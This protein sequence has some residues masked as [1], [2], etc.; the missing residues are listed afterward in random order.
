[1]GTV[2]F[3]NDHFATII[4]YGDYV[5]GNLAICHMY[6]VEGLGH[7]LF[8]VGQFCNRDLEVA[9]CSNTCYILNLEGENL[10]IGSRDSNLY[11]ISI[12]DLVASSPVCLMSKATST[13]SSLEV[14]DNSAANTLDKEDTPLSSS[15]VVEENE[16]PQIVTSSEEL[17][18]NELNTSMLMN[19]FKKKLQKLMEI[20]IGDPSKPVMIGR[21]IYTDAEMYMYALTSRLVAKGYYQE[22]GINFEESFARLEAVRMF[23]AYAAYKNFTIYQ[24]DVKTAFLNGPLKEKAFVSQPNGF[25]DPDFSN[26][27]YRLKKALYGFKQ[28][29]RAWYDKLSSFLIDHHF[30]KGEMKFFLGLQVHQSPRRIFISQSQYTL[31]ILKKHGMEKCDSISTPMATARIDVDLQG[32]STDQTK[33][34][35]MIEGL[36]Y[37]TDSR[38]NLIAYSDADHAGCHDDCK[39]TS[40]GIQFLGDKLVSWSSKK[41]DYTTMCTTKAKT[42]YQLADLFTKAFPK[43]RFEYLVHRIA[44]RCMTPTEFERLTKLSS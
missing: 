20:L 13:K 21:R 12:S 6:Y 1:M 36:M 44:M 15:T 40:R 19:Q 3:G 28:A 31:E 35:S 9:F 37:L 14:S 27:V 22:E 18:A 39:S 11:T 2:C 32:T 30:I 24:I 29:P 43:E 17:V 23:V 38:F 25:V 4:G 10:L 41:Q 34:H 5:Q 7:N 33:H 8:S 16:A 42:E 26:Y